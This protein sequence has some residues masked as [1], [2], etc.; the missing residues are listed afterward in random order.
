MQHGVVRV[1]AW[2]SIAALCLC[3]CGDD[4][5]EGN[6]GPRDED[7][8]GA[9]VSAS[10]RDSGPRD[11]GTR[12]EPPPSSRLDAGVDAG[13]D[14]GV[15]EGETAAAVVGSAGGNVSLPEGASVEIPAAALSRDVRIEIHTVEDPPPLG[16]G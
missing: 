2:I 3:G 9:K 7:E 10:C 16:E 14:A 15:R 4:S 12:S 5:E 1:T 6:G 11:S 8:C 13:L